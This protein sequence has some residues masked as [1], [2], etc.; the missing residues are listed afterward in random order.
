MAWCRR[1][2]NQ[3]GEALLFA[4]PPPSRLFSWVTP[5]LHP[6][7]SPSA[8]LRA[9]VPFSGSVSGVLSGSETKAER[10]AE[11]LAGVGPG[12]ANRTGGGATVALGC[13]CRAAQT[14]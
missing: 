3:G 4:A 5:P 13:A 8:C 11:G 10:L 7:P 1:T 9:C 2:A 12:A 6:S 14:S